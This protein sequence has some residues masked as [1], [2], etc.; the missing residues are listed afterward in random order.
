LISCWADAAAAH[1]LRELREFFPAVEIQPK[2]LLATE[3]FVS[4]PLL[5]RVASVL[6]L[7]SHFFEFQEANG[8]ACLGAHEVELGQR[9]RVI[10]TTGGGLYR[11]QLGDEIEVAGFEDA[12]PLIRFLGKSNCISDLVGEKLAEPHVRTVLER[13]FVAHGLSPRFALLAPVAEP[14]AH[15]RLFLQG[16]GLGECS[17][18]QTG[19]E[20]GLEENPHYRY[21]VQLKQLGP[22]EIEVLD[23]RGEPGW[24]VYERRC[25]ARGQRA[26][27]VKPMVLDTWTGWP[28]EFR[29]LLQNS[30]LT[31]RS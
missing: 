25:L 26:G 13:L 22:V 31:P 18:L 8:E 17:G 16:V 24:S 3:S 10:V 4:F 20:A 30:A 21:A 5:G 1:Y 29:T 11:Y 7:R 14:P 9:Y 2:G 28:A 6:A 27:N 19:L 15:Y 23:P 12:C